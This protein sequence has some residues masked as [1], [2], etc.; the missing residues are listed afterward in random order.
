MYIAFM[1]TSKEKKYIGLQLETEIIKDLK[2]Q[3]KKEHRTTAN[4]LRIIIT[5]Y[6]ESVKQD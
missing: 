6:L 5:K 3:A 4:F 1:E 2:D